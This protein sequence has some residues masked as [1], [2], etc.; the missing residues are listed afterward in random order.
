MSDHKQIDIQTLH[1]A[2]QEGRLIPLLQK[3]QAEDG[4]LS[5]ERIVAIGVETG[6]PL[7]QIYGVA[8]FYAQFRFHRACA[9]AA[10][11]AS[12]P[13][14]SGV[15]AREGRRATSSTSS[16]TPT[17]ATPAPSWT[18][19]ARGR[20][21]H[22]CS[23]AWPSPLRHRRRRGLHL[24]RA[25]YPLAIERL[26]HRH[27]QAEER[28]LL[29]ENILG[30]GFSFDIKIKEGA[31]AFVCGEETAL[32]ASIEGKRG[33]PRPG[34]RSPPSRASGASPPTSTTSRP[35]PTCPGS[36][37][38]AP[39]PPSPARHG[40]EQGHQ[41]L[42]LAGKVNNGAWSRCRWASP[43]ARS[44]SR[45][46]A[47]SRR[48]AVQ[49]RADG[50]PLGRLH[51]GRAARHADRLREPQGK[52]GAIM[53]SG[54]LVVMDETTCM[55]DVA[56]FFLDFTQSESCGKCTPCRVGTKRMLE[57]LDRITEGEGC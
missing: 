17:R 38:T 6:V 22:R 7:A 1:Y 3:A 37:S 9:A 43:S 41:G 14:S 15:H 57:I 35:S 36:S 2:G 11:P 31:G 54:G 44:S 50:R 19:R 26:Q 5:R 4:Y 53:G 13:A 27:R 32:I 42:R 49:G 56:R 39:R 30:S 20:P 40:E 55:V 23:R 24:R 47:A 25:E 33:M 48:Q 12:R 16:A 18:A 46:A 10:A 45:S 21:A 34:R 28:G 29:G 8:T 51:P 52:T